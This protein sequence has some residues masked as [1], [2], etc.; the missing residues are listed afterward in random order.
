MFF[1]NI[2]FVINFKYG[3]ISF[4][5]MHANDA[6]KEKEAGYEK[7]KQ[8][9]GGGLIIIFSTTTHAEFLRSTTSCRQNSV[10][11]L[12]SQISNFEPG[13]NE[14]MYVINRK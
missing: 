11:K 9:C 4:M 7:I 13:E 6:C 12:E 5:H 8:N 1:R 2:L 14:L 3:M 10:I